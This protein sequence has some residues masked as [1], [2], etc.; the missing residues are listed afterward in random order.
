MAALA[1]VAIIFGL[2]A[3]RDASKDKQLNSNDKIKYPTS[4]ENDDWFGM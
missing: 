3:W 1:I 2:I 4:W